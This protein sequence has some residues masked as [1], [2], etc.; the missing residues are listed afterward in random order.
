MA[1]TYDT[2]LI[3][4]SYKK[5]GNIK[6]LEE[7]LHIN[8]KIISKILKE[9]KILKNIGNKKNIDK[10][11]INNIIKDYTNYIPIKVLSKKYQINHTLISKILH[12]N[13]V[14]VSN[15]LKKKQTRITI[16]EQIETL[17]NFFKER[18]IN[19]IY[20]HKDKDFSVTFLI[21]GLFAIDIYKNSFL[22]KQKPLFMLKK[23]EECE[24]RNITLLQ[25]TEEEIKYNVNIVLNKIE[26]ILRVNIQKEKVY[27]RKTEIKEIDKD[28][29]FNF[30]NQHHIQGFVSSTIYLG[31]F[32]KSKLVGVM[33]FI[34]EGDDDWNLTRFAT[35]NNIICS[36]I[37]GKLLS[38]FIKKYK[39]FYIESFADKRWTINRENNIYTK[40]NFIYE[41][42]VYPRE[43][44]ILKNEDGKIKTYSWQKIRSFYGNK[45]TELTEREKIKK[46]NIKYYRD[47]GLFKYIW[48]KENAE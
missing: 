40:L 35:D 11:T 37:G 2:D 38:Y 16:K 24:K 12:D 48:K 21:E 32:Y 34:T 1:K 14:L 47:C 20:Q 9:K 23:R 31:C 13:D 41:H 7:T 17:I 39:P 46:Y 22:C 28:D 8:H 33:T 36:G 4:E 5:Y 15:H 44:Y 25:I 43:R 42:D 29:A 10:N 45:D 6:K 30:L 27:G 26:H 18:N 19:F 3:I